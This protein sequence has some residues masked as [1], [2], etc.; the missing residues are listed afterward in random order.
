M[1][2]F[3]VD[4]ADIFELRGHSRKR[5]GKIEA[6]VDESGVVFLYH[7]L[8]GVIRRSTIRFDPAPTKIDEGS[9]R[10]RV[11]LGPRGHS[12]IF[13]TVEC[14][15]ST[16]QQRP[17]RQF[18]TG[19]RDSR[20]AVLAQSARAAAIETSNDI[21]NEVL[22]R[23]VADLYM[24]MTDK[25]QGPIPYAGIP[26]YSTSFGRDAIIT[27]IEMLWMDPSVATGVL[28]FLAA[29]QAKEIKKDAEAEPGKIVHEMRSGEMARLGEV[30]FAFYYGSVDSTPLFVILAG[31][32]FERT[33]D[34]ALVSE[35]WPNIEA[36]LNWIDT[37]GDKDGDGFV[38]Y[39]GGETGLTNQGW[40]DSAD[41]IFHA[42]GSDPVGPIALCEVQGYVYAAK[43]LG[44]KMAAANGLAKRADELGRTRRK[45]QASL[46]RGVLVRRHR[47]LCARARWPEASL[48]GAL[49]QCRSAVVHRHRCE[50]KSGGGR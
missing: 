43:R 13:M 10:F 41:S 25:P 18:F 17:V 20:R 19:L 36:A 48:Q 46:R 15:E 37:Y 38:E 32:Y 6:R 8:D 27:A 5:R 45:S 50:G 2:H 44:A 16:R 14:E 35:L 4:F 49:V 47:D 3:A 24:L 12:S 9:A 39:Q 30:P 34:L 1:F 29:T 28:R 42:D 31:L 40:K 11:E 26:W 33:H 7:G 23:S 21:F 22:C